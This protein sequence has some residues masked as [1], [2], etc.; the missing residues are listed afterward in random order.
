[1]SA[2]AARPPQGGNDAPLYVD[3]G[4]MLLGGM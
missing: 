3:P 1:V 4:A 2:E